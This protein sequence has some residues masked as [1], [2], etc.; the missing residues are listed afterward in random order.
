MTADQVPTISLYF[1]L[2][3]ASFDSDE[4]GGIG[5]G[6]LIYVPYD[7]E[8]H[9]IQKTDVWM[10]QWRSGWEGAKGP[11]PPCCIVVSAA[12]GG[13]DSIHSAIESMGETLLAAAR[14]AVSALRLFRPGWFLHPEHAFYV[15]Y[16][17][18]L[19]VNVVRSPGPYRQAFVTGTSRLPMP[20]YAL[21]LK[22]LAKGIHAPGPISATWELLQDYRR[23]GGNAS[24]E[25]AL[26]SFNR[27]YGYQLRPA[28]R[29][30]NLFTALDSM[31]GGMNAWKIG[32]VPIKPRG[33]ARRVE[34]ALSSVADQV[35]TADL[36][37]AVHW[38]TAGSGGRGLRN[39]IAHGNGRNVEADA[40]EY[41]DQLQ[42]ITRSLLR[43]YLH[44]SSTWMQRR[45]E[46][47]PRLGISE[48][49]PL[50]AAYVT[51]LEV[52]AK[53]SGSMQDLLQRAH[54]G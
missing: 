50:A 1:P 34:A 12:L 26:E 28:S 44:F 23:S 4:V 17:P 35:S 15:F 43:Q 27:S 53:R 19:P 52:E 29:A 7:D 2:W 38:L 24:V 20:G 3:G 46:I 48:N 30:A 42:S 47:A 8:W 32:P 21:Q 9:A 40:C 41:Y 36:H 18:S 10:A 45:E 16:A 54:I 25:I 13:A 11:A 5:P 51:L 39:S 22:D 37:A 33:Y 31:L 6:V 49:S 14:T